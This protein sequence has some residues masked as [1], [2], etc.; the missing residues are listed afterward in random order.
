[1]KQ[2][3][4]AD[5]MTLVSNAVVQAADWLGLTRK[6]LADTVGV[7][8]SVI[9][10]MKSGVGTLPNKKAYELSLLLVRCYRSLFA[11]VGG[12]KASVKHWF[13][14]PN[15]HFQNAVPADMVVDV[16]GLTTVVRYLDAMRG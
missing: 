9:A 10:R 13:K 5:D 2:A 8:E 4:I 6:Q 7:S 12:D 11:I 16:S 1:M 3:A 15:K 14:T